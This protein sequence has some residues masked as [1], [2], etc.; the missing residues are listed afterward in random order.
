MKHR[1]TLRR[2]ALVAGLALGLGLAVLT[3]PAQASLAYP[4]GPT[5]IGPDI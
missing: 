5:I 3:G 2:L 4:P 1:N